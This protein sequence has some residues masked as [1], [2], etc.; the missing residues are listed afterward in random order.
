MREKMTD[1]RYGSSRSPDLA[2]NKKNNCKEKIDTM[3]RSHY[4]DMLNKK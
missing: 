2:V 3:Y 4:N 1:L